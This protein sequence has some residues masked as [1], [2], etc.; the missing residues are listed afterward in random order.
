MPPEMEWTMSGDLLECRIE[1]KDAEV[2]SFASCIHAALRYWGREFE[3]E[4]IA[5][6]AGTP[7]S[8]TWYESEDCMAWW[9]EFGN[10][11][12]IKFVGKSLGFHVVESPK[13]SYEEYRKTGEIT[14]E[15][16]EF[17]DRAK[18]AVISGEVVL[19][20]TWPSWSIITRWDDDYSKIELST[21]QHLKELCSV[22]PFMEAYILTPGPAEYT[23][24]ESLKEALKFGADVADGTFHVPGFQY[25]GKLYEA[26]LKRMEHD[27]FCE[28]C[29][30][31]SWSCA[32]RTMA[33]V[34]GTN[35]D[36]VSFLEF[37]GEFLGD[38]LPKT[39]LNEA[40]KGFRAIA[41]LS[42]AYLNRELLEDNWND[43]GFRDEFTS[44]VQSMKVRHR[45]T[46]GILRRLAGGL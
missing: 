42:R 38:Q 44:K 1:G 2:D 34:H 41:D 11:N 23:R 3:Y 35:N 39:V 29:G 45:D 9:T 16:S 30:D 26:I 13:M 12:R 10:G 46:A 36:A 33:R 14:K 32:L 27:V 24:A 18:E 17:W 25:G 7:F 37:A 15:H 31:K 8:P 4:Y 22:Q 40:I 28:S 43:A 21:M 6:L 19:V 20:K 5:G